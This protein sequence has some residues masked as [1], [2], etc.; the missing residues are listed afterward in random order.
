M[1]ETAAFLR[2]HVFS[3]VKNIENTLGRDRQKTKKTEICSFCIFW[4][5]VDSF[6]VFALKVKIY[7]FEFFGFFQS[8]E[9]KGAYVRGISMFWVWTKWCS[10]PKKRTLDDKK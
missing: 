4:Q 7:F 6:R 8:W 3:K 10:T 9:N 5:K 1:L 2:K